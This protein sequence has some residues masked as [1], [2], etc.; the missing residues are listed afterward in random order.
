MC[1]LSH[2]WEK[3]A[4]SSSG[5][6][7]GTIY[8]HIFRKNLASR[9]RAQGAR[10]GKWIKGGKKSSDPHP[11]FPLPSGRRC[12]T[13]IR[14]GDSRA[15][16]E[17]QLLDELSKA[18]AIVS[19]RS[20][21]DFS[22]DF[23]R[24]GKW[25]ERRG[26]VNIAEMRKSQRG[27]GHRDSLIAPLISRCERELFRATLP[28]DRFFFNDFVSDFFPHFQGWRMWNLWW[29]VCEDFPLLRGGGGCINC[30]ESRLLGFLWA[31]YC[32]QKFGK[33]KFWSYF[34]G[35][36]WFVERNLFVH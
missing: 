19:C 22:R 18:R 2:E 17:R 6:K 36:I 10:D 1:T 11:V 23:R 12:G 30:E 25:G 9:E 13:K 32:V 27:T 35:L 33:L 29:C 16:A 21:A 3:S 34:S 7:L 26:V 28:L 4:L 8:K 5:T 14:G 31:R 24:A 20:A 15:R